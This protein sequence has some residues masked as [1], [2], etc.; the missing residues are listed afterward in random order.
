APAGRAAGAAE[1]S[2]CSRAAFAAALSNADAVRLPEP[3]TTRTSAL[4]LTQP[5]RA[6]TSPIGP[7]R[8]GVR[9]AA[10]ADPTVDHA[11]G[12]HATEAVVRAR[13]E[14]FRDEVVNAAAWSAACARIASEVVAEPVSSVVN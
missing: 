13:L 6:I 9:C 14:R 12:V 3:V 4:P 11:A 10:P 1:Y 7:A 8:L 5:A 2:T